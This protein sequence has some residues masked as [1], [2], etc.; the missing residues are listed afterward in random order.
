[1]LSGILIDYPLFR[2]LNVNG[3]RTDG[4]VRV[5]EVCDREMD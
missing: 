3:S 2:M 1:M 4:P 5:G